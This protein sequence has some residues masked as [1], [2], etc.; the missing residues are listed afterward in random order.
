MP[1][2]A[3]QHLPLSTYRL[4][5]HA[6]F[7]FADVE[8][9]LPYLQ[10]LGV[11]DCYFSPVFMSTPEST[12]GYDVSDY[13]KVDPKLGGDA[14]LRRIAAELQNRDMAVLLD[15][16]PNHMS[17]NG[18]LNPWWQDVLEGGSHSPYARFFDIHWNQHHAR[19]AARNGGGSTIPGLRP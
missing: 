14:G 8:K 1:L 15:F 7:T 17:V 5:L 13:R 11:T 6:G 12:H 16:V 2:N 9:V 4:Q 10:R 18:P 3:A 19:A